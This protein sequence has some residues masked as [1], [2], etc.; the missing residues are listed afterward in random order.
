MV[1]AL[2]LWWWQAVWLV[3]NPKVDFKTTK[4]LQVSWEAVM[5]RSVRTLGG[6][7]VSERT[8]IDGLWNCTPRGRIINAA[9]SLS[10]STWKK[11]SCKGPAVC[12]CRW[13]VFE[14][15]VACS[16]GAAWAKPADVLTFWPA[17][18]CRD[19]LRIVPAQRS[20]M[21]LTGAAH[22]EN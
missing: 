13:C 6:I 1:R 16:F 3:K 10:L 9:S 8:K 20:L 7:I 18:C 19:G 22:L 12:C 4:G 17:Q 21:H 5:V 14:Q 2:F 15:P 11:S